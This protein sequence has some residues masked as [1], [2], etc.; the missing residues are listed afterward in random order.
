M[1]SKE[2][3]KELVILMLEILSRATVSA[4][5]QILFM[6]QLEQAIIAKDM[7]S[8]SK[9]IVGA[10]AYQGFAGLNEWIH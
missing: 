9:I 5:D 2:E 1:I 10:R 6:R 7:G 4:E 3:E 8:I